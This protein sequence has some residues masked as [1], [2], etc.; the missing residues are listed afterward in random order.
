MFLGAHAPCVLVSAPCRNALLLKKMDK[1]LIS[2]DSRAKE[3]SRCRGR[4]RQHAE[5]R[6]ALEKINTPSSAR[7]RDDFVETPIA[8]QS[9]YFQLRNSVSVIPF[10]AGEVSS[11]SL[12]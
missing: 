8:S 3:S 1:A 11:C 4:H 6:C 2:F 9:L 5:A 12:E 7:P 10:A